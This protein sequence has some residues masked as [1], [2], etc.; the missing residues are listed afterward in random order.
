MYIGIIGLPQT[1]SLIAVVV[2]V[3]TSKSN[4]LVLNTTS[5]L[6]AISLSSSLENNFHFEYDLI[7]LIGSWQT[8]IL[9]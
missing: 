8:P 5:S 4:S 7:M 1:A 2:A 6:L 3:S 9:S